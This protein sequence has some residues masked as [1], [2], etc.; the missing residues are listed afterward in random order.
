MNIKVIKV[1]NNFDDI[2]KIN[3]LAK[4]AFPPEEYLSPK[5]L[6]EMSGSS[7]INFLA[8]YD[9]SLFVGFV[10]VQI[11]KKMV[12]LFFLAIENSLRSKGY[13]K[14]I[15]NLLKEMYPNYQNVVDFE[16][17]DSKSKNYEQRKRRRNFYLKN[18]YKETGYFLN[19]LDVDYEIFSMDENFDVDEF[20]ELLSCLKIEGFNPKFF[21]N[22][23]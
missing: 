14:S 15:I 17:V 9:E 6:I 10:V 1:T 4:E 13:G 21:Q 19:Y 18:G 8:I 22:N 11:Y 16:M 20:K 7:G 5:K 23:L 12:Y 2:D 3:I